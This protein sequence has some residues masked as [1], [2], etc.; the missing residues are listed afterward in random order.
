MKL[1]ELDSIERLDLSDNKIGNEPR[2]ELV[3]LA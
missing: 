3:N 1:G 2:S